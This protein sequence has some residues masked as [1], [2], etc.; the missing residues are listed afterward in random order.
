MSRFYV[1]SLAYPD[2]EVFYIG[3]GSGSRLQ[4]LQAQTSEAKSGK[5]GRKYDII[6]G[7]LATGETVLTRRLVAWWHHHCRRMVPVSTDTL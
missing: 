1:Y 6:R 3:K 2:G 7:I 5:S 4:R